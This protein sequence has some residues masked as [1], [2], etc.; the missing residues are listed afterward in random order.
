M[1]KPAFKF[2]IKVL[3][4]LSLIRCIFFIYNLHSGQRLKINN[5]SVALNVIG[6]SVFYDVCV[7]SFLSLPLAF[8]LVIF[9]KVKAI[10]KIILLIFSALFAFM[11]L[12]NITD[13][14]YFPF[15]L[16]RADDELLYVLRNPFETGSATYFL[17][18]AS[19]IIAFLLL[20]L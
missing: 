4:L 9:K 1:F 3:I 16:Q 14:F 8:L 12:L 10:E 5:F 2:L 6:W 11:L 20:V 17:I 19:I 13:I 15:K 18:S 7:I